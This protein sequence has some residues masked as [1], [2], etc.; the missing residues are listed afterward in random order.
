MVYGAPITV[1][2][3]FLPNYNVQSER[4]HLQ[5]LHDRVRSL[6]PIPTSW[7]G[8]RHAFLPHNLQK[9]KFVFIRRDCHRT[10]LQRPYEGPFKVI[11][12]GPKT[13]KVEIG[14][15]S[16]MVSVD[17]LKIAHV[18]T[19]EPPQVAVPK[20]RGRPKTLHRPVTK[21]Q[22]GND[23]RPQYTRSGRQVKCPHRYIS[24]LGGEWCSRPGSQDA[25]FYVTNLRIT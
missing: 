15:R 6:V 21:R 22:P 4:S 14:G 17:R 1:P 20:R 3:D 24:V 9:A 10:P 23:L 12:P 11:Q 25:V 2:G 19:E 8:T 5:Q 7:H 13:F 18:D 16:E